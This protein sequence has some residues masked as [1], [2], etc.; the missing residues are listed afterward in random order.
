MQAGDVL[1]L[2]CLALQ[3]LFKPRYGADGRAVGVRDF[4]REAAEPE[5]VI[6]AQMKVFK[7][8][9]IDDLFIRKQ[10]FMQAQRFVVNRVNAHHVKADALVTAV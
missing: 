9:N 6:A 3:R 10:L 1:L 7:V 5:Q 8:F 2:W 4:K